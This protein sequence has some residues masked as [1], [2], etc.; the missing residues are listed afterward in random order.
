[1]LQAVKTETELAVALASKF[2]LGE[3][4]KSQGLCLG[5]KLTYRLRKHMDTE[6]DSFHM[7]GKELTTTKQ[8]ELNG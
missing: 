1:M 3:N 5:H 6:A 4:T 7:W 8:S 2:P